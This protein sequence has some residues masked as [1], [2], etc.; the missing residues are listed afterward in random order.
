M[1]I[2]N[3]YYVLWADV[4][5]RIKRSHPENNDW[6]H[7]SLFL[8]SFIFSLNIMILIS[9]LKYFSVID[10]PLLHFNLTPIKSINTPISLS[11]EFLMPCYLINYFLIFYKDKYHNILEHYPETKI[12]Y[13]VIYV[14]SIIILFILSSILYG[15]L[16]DPLFIQKITGNNQG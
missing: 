2:R 3:I 4:V 8:M 5:I 15:Y 11:I 12:K 7:I 10:I 14:F 6:K 9:W 13:S 1:K 16:T